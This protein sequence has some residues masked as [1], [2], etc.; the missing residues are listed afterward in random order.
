MKTLHADVAAFVLTGLC[1]VAVAILAAIEVDIPEVLVTV[2]LVAIGA[3]GGAALPRRVAAMPEPLHT[4]HTPA[5]APA[6]APEP[7]RESA[8]PRI[9]ER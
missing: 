4:V 6:P 3:S 9:V 7:A 1:I 2:A 5:P 8:G